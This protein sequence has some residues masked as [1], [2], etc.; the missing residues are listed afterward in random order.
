MRFS[1]LGYRQGATCS[2]THTSLGT[3]KGNITALLEDAGDIGG[4]RG[5]SNVAYASVTIVICPEGAQQESPGQSGAATRRSAVEV[6]A[7]LKPVTTVATYSPFARFEPERLK[8][9]SSGQSRA[10]TRR[11]AALG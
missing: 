7:G 4:R 10:A 9:E 5:H 1:Q 6:V 3:E 11:S 2:L 8:Q